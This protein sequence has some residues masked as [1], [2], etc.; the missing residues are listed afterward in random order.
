MILN[1]LSMFFR[2][3]AS[4]V[5]PSIERKL[6]VQFFHIIV[7]I[8]FCQDGCSC[9]GEVFPIAFHD[10]RV[11]HFPFSIRQ[12]FVTINNQMLIVFSSNS[13]VNNEGLDLTATIVEPITRMVEGYAN[14]PLVRIDGPL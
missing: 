9:N 11:R 12:E 3:I 4:I 6:F 5:I 10:G 13:A 1:T 2:R 14:V 7:T 8:S